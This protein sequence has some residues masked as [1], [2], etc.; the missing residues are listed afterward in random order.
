MNAVL[1][2]TKTARCQLSIYAV[3]RQSGVAV[4]RKKYPNGPSQSAA[5][6]ML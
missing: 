4:I 2:T 6:V 3:C 1:E 5:G